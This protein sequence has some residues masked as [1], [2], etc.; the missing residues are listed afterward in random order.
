[1]FSMSVIS[2]ISKYVWLCKVFIRTLQQKST[3][4]GV[5]LWEDC[6]VQIF[7]VSEERCHLVTYAR[8]LNAE[9]SA[10]STAL[11]NCPQCAAEF[12][13]RVQRAN[14]QREGGCPGTKHPHA[15]E[16]SLKG[17][18][19]EH[20]SAGDAQALARGGRMKPYPCFHSFSTCVLSSHYVLTDRG[21]Q[22]RHGPC[23]HQADCFVGKSD[24][25]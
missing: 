16:P 4:R 1:M 20:W 12:G 15:Q 14:L 19:T 18:R 6:N 22:D 8:I 11:K 21:S 9:H 10:V 3:F 2:N 13:V 23:P 7:S 5:V 25:E 24:I 17:K